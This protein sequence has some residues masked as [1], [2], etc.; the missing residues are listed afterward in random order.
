MRLN[1]WKDKVISFALA[2]V[3]IVS[4][5]TSGNMSEVQADTGNV[6]TKAPVITSISIDK[7]GEIVEDGKVTI[8]FTAWDE[9]GFSDT[10]GASI[11]MKNPAIEQYTSTDV[12]PKKISTSE[13]G[14]SA[15]YTASFWI[16]DYVAGE[17]YLD[18]IS[19]HDTYLNSATTLAN[20]VNIL[21]SYYFYV[22]G[23]Y[24]EITYDNVTINLRDKDYQLLATT[25]TTTLPKRAKVSEILGNKWIQTLPDD[26]KLGKFIGWR[27]SDDLLT[28]EAEVC[29]WGD[30]CTLDLRPVYEKQGLDLQYTYIDENLDEVTKYKRLLLPYDATYADVINTLDIPVVAGCNLL[31][32][33]LFSYEGDTINPVYGYLNITAQYDAY[34]VTVNTIY[35][36]ANNNIVKDT[37][38]KLYPAGT[39]RAQIIDTE[40][41]SMDTSIKNSAD[42]WKKSNLAYADLRSKMEID[43]IAYYT[44]K[45]MVKYESGYIANTD[46]STEYGEYF[47]GN[48]YMI[49]SNED[50][51]SESTFAQA[52]SN[53]VKLNLFDGFTRVSHKYEYYEEYYNNSNVATGRY[54]N[55]YMYSPSY[56]KPYVC[57]R[58]DGYVTGENF[59]RYYVPDSDTFDLPTEYKGQL[60]Y[61]YDV[62]ADVYYTGSVSVSQTS[63]YLTMY[64]E[65]P[66]DAVVINTPTKH[67]HDYKTTTVPATLS[68]NGSKTKKCDACGDVAS[69]ST[70]YKISSVKLSTTEY[71][72]TGAKKTPTVTVKDSKGKKL[73]EGKNYKLT[74]SSSTR[75]DIGRYSVKVTFIGDY[76]GSK[77]LYF[78]IGPKNPTSVKAALYGYDDVKVSWSKVSG[79]S[80]YKVYYKKS[81]TS[82]W[83]SK[84][85]TGTSLK[86]ANLAD[87]AKYDVKVVT[88]KTKSGYKCY[89][90]GKST[91][92]YTLKKVTGIK[93][94]KSGT[95]VKVS[96]TNIAGES[97]YQISKSTKKSG[98]SIAATYNTTSGKYKT[99]S[100]TKKKTY[101]YKVRAYKVVDG[102]KIYGPWSTAVKYVRK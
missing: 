102:K 19:V 43:F 89:N 27:W 46:K 83:S 95:K 5:I 36:D 98:T 91:S 12:W 14:K 96:W 87:G 23:E 81:T 90:A 45:V 59:A 39:E 82:T 44:D 66:E 55:F 94:A 97:G 9:S 76:S 68:S 13:D 37:H 29:V 100:A 101:Y 20:G 57:L 93:A 64:S 53:K 11:T 51:S 4:V 6:D 42:D 22:A 41:T 63:L 52:V 54:D 79:A 99:I 24:E 26:K 15:T 73:V 10:H 35:A 69:K 21:R 85:T 80:G 32:W 17:W 3:M 86:L 2:L 71:T 60:L 77:T 70:I 84:T 8:T 74:Y 67:E 30:G 31:N 56:D 34:P 1:K 65:I 50:A 40:F 25:G 47:H 92:V 75:K 18:N 78:T 58:D 33:N 49:V 62:D 7:Q 61:W 28:Q 88:Y 48:H 72:Y 16:T 38:T